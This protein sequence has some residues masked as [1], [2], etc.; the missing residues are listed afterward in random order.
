MEKKEDRR[1][2]MT[3]RIINV[4]NYS[5]VVIQISFYKIVHIISSLLLLSARSLCYIQ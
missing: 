3:K 1:V 2:A 4:D 5:V